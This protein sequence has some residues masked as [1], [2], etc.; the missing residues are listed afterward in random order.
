LFSR[1]RKRQPGPIPGGGRLLTAAALCAL[2]I[3]PARAD[4]LH[5]GIQALQQG[6]YEQAEHLFREAARLKPQDPVPVEWLTRLF[7]QTME[8]AALNAALTEL[9][10]R[11]DAMR[12]PPSRPPA[13]P[14]AKPA[15]PGMPARIQ[16][17]GST[18]PKRGD[19]LV[20]LGPLPPLPP[21]PLT[22]TGGPDA[23]PAQTP[24]WKQWRLQKLGASLSALQATLRQLR[25][26]FG[27]SG[28]A[29]AKVQAMSRE[30]EQ[31]VANHRKAMTQLQSEL[32]E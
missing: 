23:P 18:M 22:Q 6:Q 1:S 14:A 3:L 19:D 32:G 31:K 2:V 20:D 25:E 5:D 13:K 12:R 28:Q 7:E 21:D 26:R 9:N 29:P 17:D 4:A 8:P 10:R 15:R 27:A 11:R 16:L 30:I 24:A